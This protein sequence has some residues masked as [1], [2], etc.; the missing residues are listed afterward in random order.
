M[1]F[2]K[3]QNVELLNGSF[4]LLPTRFLVFGLAESFVVQ[5]PE[6]FLNTLKVLFIV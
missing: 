4:H 2:I 3:I 5:V 1:F 6:A